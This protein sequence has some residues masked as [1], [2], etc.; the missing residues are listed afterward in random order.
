[1]LMLL[2]ERKWIKMNLFAYLCELKTIH[3]NLYKLKFSW[4]YVSLHE[5][6]WIYVNLYGFMWIYATMNRTD[7][8]KLT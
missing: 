3:T 8:F 1:M 4:I 7:L 2:D 5:F 6:T